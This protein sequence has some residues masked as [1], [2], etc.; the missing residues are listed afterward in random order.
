MELFQTLL[1]IG[2]RYVVPFS[3][4]GHVGRLLGHLDHRPHDEGLKSRLL[5]SAL[6]YI[7]WCL[8]DTYGV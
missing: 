7:A 5:L 2:F 3:I 8:L 1:D 6:V 4:A